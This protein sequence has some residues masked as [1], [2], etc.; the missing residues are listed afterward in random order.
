MLNKCGAGGAELA[1][2]RLRRY[3]NKQGLLDSK[4][5]IG[6]NNNVGFEYGS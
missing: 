6:K 4:T 1:A 3:S 2:K 5:N